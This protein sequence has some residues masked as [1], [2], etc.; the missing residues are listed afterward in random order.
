M[1]IDPRPC[2]GDAF[3]MAGPRLRALRCENCVN[4][5]HRGGKCLGRRGLVHARDAG[6][7]LRGDEWKAVRA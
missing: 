3:R 1:T 2:Q 4:D 5:P 6:I 7:Q